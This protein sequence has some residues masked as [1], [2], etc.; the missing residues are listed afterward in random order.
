M[1]ENIINN[2]GSEDYGT[3]EASNTYTVPDSV[4]DSTISN[5]N[6]NEVLTPKP[7][8]KYASPDEDFGTIP[9]SPPGPYTVPD[10]V[11]DSSVSNSNSGEVLTPKP[12][13]KYASPDDE[14]GASPTIPTFIDQHGCLIEGNADVTVSNAVQENSVLAP[15][16]GTKFA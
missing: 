4:M 11:S 12:G 7:G 6:G 5:A 9:T 1:N 14:Y 10:T 3:I 16:P 13:T 15:K 8:T 2:P